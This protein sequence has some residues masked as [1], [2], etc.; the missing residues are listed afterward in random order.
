MDTEYIH[1]FVVIEKEWY[2][3]SLNNTSYMLRDPDLRKLKIIIIWYNLI[4]RTYNLSA[5]GSSKENVN[6]MIK[7]T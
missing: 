1:A 3:I 6:A 4:N 2:K 7:L 5:L